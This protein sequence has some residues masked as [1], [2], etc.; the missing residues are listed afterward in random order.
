MASH[1]YT[2][3]DDLLIASSS[4]DEHKHHLRAGFQRLDE[5][6]IVLN[7]LKCAF[8]VKELT[9]LGYHISSSGIR[10]FEDKV[11]AVRDFP[12]PN[13]QRKVREFLDV[14]NLYHWFLNHGAAILKPLNDLLADPKGQKKELVWTDVPLKAFMVAKDGLANATLS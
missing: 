7:P 5:Y 10:P 12:Q 1:T 6:G 9:F 14:I 11:Q 4:A 3:I 2:Y 8:E 13:T